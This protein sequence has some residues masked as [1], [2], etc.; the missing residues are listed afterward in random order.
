MPWMR[1]KKK[2]KKK[3]KDRKKQGEK[4]EI[5]TVHTFIWGLDLKQN[6]PLVLL[7]QCGAANAFLINDLY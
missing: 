6:V 1:Q 5:L 3:K 4:E 2:K 7:L